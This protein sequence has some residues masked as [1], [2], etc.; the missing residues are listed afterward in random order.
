MG[1][2]AT[3][4]VVDDEPHVVRLVQA[5]L[6]ASG[7]RVLVAGDGRTALHVVEQ[8]NPDLVLLDIMMAGL[9]GYEVCRRLREYSDVPVIMLTARGAEVDRIA[10]FDV[11]ADDYLTK[12]F[13]VGELLARVRAVL[14]RC[15]YPNEVRSRPRFRSGPLEIDFAQHKVTVGGR[16]VGLSPTEYRLLSALA[17]N[18]GCVVLHEDLLR[19]VWGP[20]YRDE[21]EY[22]RVY[23]RYLRQKIET[24]P[25]HPQLILTHPGAGYI[26][27]L[28]PTSGPPAAPGA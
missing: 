23:V 1:E 4:L 6:E 22:L 13:A 16:V 28:L 17:R 26:L 20:E 2:K 18:A 7:Y 3:I 25:A 8:Q 15:K 11:G 5:N 14:R 12:P 21:K 24:D 10:G 9:D 19:Q 27:A